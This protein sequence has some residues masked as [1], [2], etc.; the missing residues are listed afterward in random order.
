MLIL[1]GAALSLA[2]VV[3]ILVLLYL[4]RRARRR[5]Y[6]EWRRSV[7]RWMSKPN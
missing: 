1:I 7:R 2:T 4:E 3:I 5:R 6:A